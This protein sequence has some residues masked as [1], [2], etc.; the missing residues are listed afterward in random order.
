M[1]T[2][3]IL[4]LRYFDTFIPVFS[5]ENRWSTCDLHMKTVIYMV[6]KNT[7]SA[8]SLAG[9][10]RIKVTVTI[11]CSSAKHGV[12]TNSDRDVTIYIMCRI[13]GYF[14]TLNWKLD[15]EICDL[16]ETVCD[17]CKGFKFGSNGFLHQAIKIK[18]ICLSL[19]KSDDLPWNQ[20]Q[21][22]FFQSFYY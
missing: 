2:N 15:L 3:F 10:I 1:N 21:D 18:N 8:S 5:S 19:G 4:T 7:C 17:L 6:N 12:R 22:G 14:A 13:P 11:I 20:P 16:C 9:L